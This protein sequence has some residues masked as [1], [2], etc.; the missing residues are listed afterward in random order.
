MLVLLPVTD[1]LIWGI[2]ASGVSVQLTYLLNE[3]AGTVSLFR[4]PKSQMLQPSG[5]RAE[6]GAWLRPW[7]NPEEGSSHLQGTGHVAQKK[8]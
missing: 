4:S 2:L 8:N 5:I 6:L 7:G 1:R 3:L